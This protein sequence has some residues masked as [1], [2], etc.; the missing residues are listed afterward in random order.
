MIYLKVWPYVTIAHKLLG[1]P[2]GMTTQ[3]CGLDGKVHKIKP[4]R[5]IFKY[6]PI[7]HKDATDLYILATPFAIGGYLKVPCICNLII[8]DIVIMQDMARHQSGIFMFKYINRN[9]PI[10]LL[11][12]FNCKYEVH[13]IV[14]TLESHLGSDQLGLVLIT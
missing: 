3:K 8:V 12:I 10:P 1:L 6:S 5:N 13:T 4:D 7:A 9:L 2:L 11:P 14:K